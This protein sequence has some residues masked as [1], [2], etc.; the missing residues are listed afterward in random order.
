MVLNVYMQ[1]LKQE[2]VPSKLTRITSGSGISR[3]EERNKKLLCSEII[4]QII[5]LYWEITK[6]TIWLISNKLSLILWTYVKLLWCKARSY[7]QDK[8]LTKILFGKYFQ[9]YVCLLGAPHM[10][11]AC[12]SMS[13]FLNDIMLCMKLKETYTSTGN[14]L[15]A[16]CLRLFSPVCNNN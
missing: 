6:F 14:I 10:W 7:P 15:E 4:A 11:L 9:H 16:K 2:K 5:Y 3:T 8:W 1:F 12:H 13:S